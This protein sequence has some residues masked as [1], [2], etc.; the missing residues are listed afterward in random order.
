MERYPLPRRQASVPAARRRPDSWPTPE[1]ERLLRAALLRGPRALEAWDEWKAG[2]DINHLDGGSYRLLPQ[3]YQNLYRHGVDE[4]VLVLFRGVYR[5]T[6]YENQLRFHQ[7]ARLLRSFRDAGIDAMVL[8]GAALTVLYYKDGGVRPMH[9]VDLLVHEGAVGKARELVR[10]ARFAPWPETA[11][12][13]HAD[14]F[15]DAAGRQVDLHWGVFAD[16]PRRVS[17]GPFWDGAVS[18]A[19]H[20]VPAFA[21]NP[22]DQLLHVCVHGAPWKPVPT[23]RWVADAMA[24]L[25]AAP[26]AVDWNRVFAQAHTRRLTLPLRDTLGY[27]RDV[28]DA[29]IP[30]SILTSLCRARTSVAE[31]I[32]YAARTRSTDLR[33]PWLSLYDLYRSHSAHLPA[34]AGALRTLAEFPRFL[35]RAWGAGH[36]WQLPGVAAVKLLR[37]TGRMASSYRCQRATP[38]HRI[39]HLSRGLVRSGR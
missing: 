10:A 29:P 37:W 6:W 21:L 31:R 12:P 7:L 16:N 15:Q 17:D 36:V 39:D 2:A 23:I 35:Q 5:R 18:I 26:S 27:L 30:D 3:L 19:I 11:P 34:E 9:D 33:G 14:T 20:G 32:A 25:G 1:Q 8:K 38:G 22:S 13:P 24:I 28:F 4:P